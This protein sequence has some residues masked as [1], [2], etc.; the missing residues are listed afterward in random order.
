MATQRLVCIIAATI[1][2]VGS[3]ALGLHWL[4]QPPVGSLAELPFALN[5]AHLLIA[6]LL[7]ACAATALVLHGRLRAAAVTLC[8]AGIVPGLFEPRAFV[9]TFALV[10]AGLVTPTTS[11]PGRPARG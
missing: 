7:A 8:V 9:V 3:G 4:T 11:A 6:A 2:G 1:G 5:A 10:F